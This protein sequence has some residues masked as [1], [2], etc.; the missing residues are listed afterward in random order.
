M[1]N[2]CCA[3]CPCPDIREDIISAKTL[4]IDR[5]GLAPRI[6]TLEDVERVG[7]RCGAAPRLSNFLL[8]GKITGPLIK[9]AAGIKTKR[10]P[11]PFPH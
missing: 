3:L 10:K 6:R 1:R 2:N 9:K 11:P 5:D 4:F 8:H 7:K